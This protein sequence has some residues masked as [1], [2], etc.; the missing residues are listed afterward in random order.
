M[1]ILDTPAYSQAAAD[2]KFNRPNLNTM[3][4]DGDSFDSKNRLVSP[5]I[6]V[7]GGAGTFAITVDGST[8]SDLAYNASTA[9]VQTA[10]AALASVGTGNVTVSGTAGASYSLTMI[11]TAAQKGDLVSATGAGGAT[12]RVDK[13]YSNSAQGIMSWVNVLTRQRLKYYGPKGV[14]GSTSDTF[15]SRFDT[16]IKPLNPGWVVLTSPCSNDVASSTSAATIQTR[17]TQYMDKCAAIGARLIISTIPPRNALTT[18]QRNVMSAVNRWIREQG[19]TRRGVYVVDAWQLLVDPTNGGFRSGVAS[20]GVHLNG[21]GSQR[22]G[23]AIAN[24][25]NTYSPPVDILG[26]GEDV[27]LQAVM[28]NPNMTGTT[29]TLSNSITGQAATSWTCQSLTGAAITAVASKVART[30]FLPGEWQQVSVSAGEGCSIQQ[31]LNF[32]GITPGTTYIDA[33]C[34]FQT[35]VDWANTTSF[36]MTIAFLDNAFAGVGA[37]TDLQW[38]AGDTYDLVNTRPGSGVFRIP[39]VLVPAAATKATVSVQMKGQG[40]LRVGRFGVFRS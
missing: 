29:G 33:M 13:S 9:T 39:R 6:K 28:T 19:Q 23:A 16:N 31:N 38:V 18:A 5:V 1:G 3:V 36:H 17:L 21:I 30:D 32:A 10:V 40:T 22:V 2:A 24:I 4:S 27:E 35:D 15:V 20:D 25:I 8:T 34:E 7:S 26:W 14:F 37:S 11:S 12:V